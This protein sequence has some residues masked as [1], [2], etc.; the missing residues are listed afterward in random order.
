M[1]SRWLG[2]LAVALVATVPARGQDD[3]PEPPRARRPRAAA[4]TPAPSTQLTEERAFLNQLSEA[5]RNLG[6]Q[7]Q[8]IHDRIEVLHDELAERADR[9]SAVEEE[10]K[11]LRDEVKGLYVESSTVKERIDGLKEDVA[12][13]DS[14][15]SSFRTFAGLFI[16]LTTVLLAVIFALT[17]R[18]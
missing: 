5:Q 3:E 2:L 12:G 18:R 4:R 13:V 8:Q 11:A 6:E 7:L 14:S 10:V 17:V 15:V 16:A 9:D 1:K